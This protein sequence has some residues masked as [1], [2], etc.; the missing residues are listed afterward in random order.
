MSQ[1]LLS[2]QQLRTQKKPQKN[3]ST[4][5]EIRKHLHFQDFG[6]RWYHVFWKKTDWLNVPQTRG[7]GVTSG[8]GWQYWQYKYDS[9]N[10]LGQLQLFVLGS[11]LFCFSCI[12]F[13]CVRIVCL[14]ACRL[15]M[16]YFYQLCDS[17]FCCRQIKLSLHSAGRLLVIPDLIWFNLTWFL[18]FNIFEQRDNLVNN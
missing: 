12:R 7:G 6:P 13:L 16:N 2:Q 3:N 18:N 10:H 9:P 14:Y 5:E 1:D 17:E 8:K 11:F 4:W 15:C